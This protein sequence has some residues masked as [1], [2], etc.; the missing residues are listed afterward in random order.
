MINRI[1]SGIV[2][3]TL[4]G[5]VLVLDPSYEQVKWQY[6]Q[7]VP[8]FDTTSGYLSDGEYGVTDTGQ[9][10]YKIDGQMY[11]LDEN[12]IL[13][14][15]LKEVQYLGVKYQDVFEGGLVDEV[16]QVEYE[17]LKTGERQPIKTKLKMAGIAEG[18]IVN[19]AT[20]F[21]DSSGFV[22]PLTLSIDCTETDR[23]VMTFIANRVLTEITGVTHNSDAM[24]AEVN[25]ENTSVAGTAIYSRTA[26]DSG[27]NN[28]V[29]SLSAFRLLSVY[30]VCL[31]GTDQ[32]DLVEATSSAGTFGTTLTTSATSLT[33]NAW[34]MS[35]INLQGA[36]TL[37]PDAGETELNDSDHS[38]G[39]LGRFGVSYY[40]KATAGSETIGWSWTGGDNA[41]I[42]LVVVKPSS[43][44]GGGAEATTT[45]K[46]QIKGGVEIKGGLQLR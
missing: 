14:S 17:D 18:A 23:G 7:S 40:E 4:I 45:P 1:I 11:S 16:E 25:S 5:G 42:A 34:F 24:T 43:G 39:S 41:R 30:N 29:V 10:L 13:L 21:A 22:N 32:T 33:N 2:G 31:S 8:Y 46:M 26:A 15:N 44:G 38:D 27:T 9:V 19:E 12:P 20:N 37:T 35:S 6:S 36:A 3:V 28:V